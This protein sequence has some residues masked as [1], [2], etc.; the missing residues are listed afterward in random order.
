MVRLSTLAG[1]DS[2]RH[3]P[4]SGPR[5]YIVG[6]LETLIRLAANKWPNSDRDHIS[7]T[8]S[9]AMATTANPNHFPDPP[10]HVW[11]QN[12]CNGFTKQRASMLDAT[13]MSQRAQ[14]PIVREWGP[15]IATRPGQSLHHR[16]CLFSVSDIRKRFS[17]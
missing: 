1:T 5:C 8:S 10:V 6:V 2:N 4:Q 12:G 17:D 7:F 14:A 11:P 13:G 15:T 3:V 9:C 16:Q